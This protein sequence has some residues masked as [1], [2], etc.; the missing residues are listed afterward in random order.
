MRHISSK[1]SRH[2][3]MNEPSHGFV[4][5]VITHISSTQCSELLYRNSISTHNTEQL[6]SCVSC[7]AAGHLNQHNNDALHF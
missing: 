2:F 4:F 1:W 6:I 5:F 3:T 7:F